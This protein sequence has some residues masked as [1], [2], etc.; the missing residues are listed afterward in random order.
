MIV[1][2]FDTYGQ[3]VYDVDRDEIH[4][5]EL[6]ARPK[7]TRKRVDLETF[8][9]LIEDTALVNW[10][11]LQVKQGYK[12]YNNTGI[13]PHVNID[14]RVLDAIKVSSHLPNGETFPFTLEITQ[15]QGLPTVKRIQ[16]LRDCENCDVTIALD[17]YVISND[18]F[19][20]TEYQFD[21]IKLDRSMIVRAETD[22]R[23]VQR[24]TDL[25]NRFPT[26]EFVVEGVENA[27]QVALMR[28]IGFNLFQGYYFHKP[29][30]LDW[31][32]EHY[33]LPEGTTLETAPKATIRMDD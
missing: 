25:V 28:S 32:F 18:I 19:K 3:F 16:K 8:F 30:P 23:Y 15:V 27:H 13:H 5:V 20:I 14:R 17:D 11:D 26:T 6:L 4:S 10:F 33:R 31:L 9:E 12:F 29:E 24:L 1:H 2:N 7:T 22:Y 21:I